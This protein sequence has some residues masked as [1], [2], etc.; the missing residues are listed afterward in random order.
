MNANE[1]LM[2][3]II[4]SMSSHIDATTCSILKDVLIII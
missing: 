2:K 3:E 1:I 4:M